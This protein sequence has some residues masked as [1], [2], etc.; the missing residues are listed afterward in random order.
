MYKFKYK[1]KWFWKT[2]K[3]VGHSYQENQDKM[4]LYYEDGSVK[5]IVKWSNCAVKLGADWVR[6]TQKKMEREAGVQVP[7]T[8]GD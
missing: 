8:T 7:V 5:E 6:V 2:E 1:R 4:C 3:V